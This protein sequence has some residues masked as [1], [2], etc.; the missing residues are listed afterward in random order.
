MGADDA[1][2][3]D[4]AAIEDGGTNADQAIHSNAASMER[5]SVPDHAA[6]ADSERK[7]WIG[8]QN[9]TVL[10]I[11]SLLDVDQFV[12]AA[13]HRAKPDTDI[14]LELDPTNHDGRRCNPVFAGGRCFNASTVK[15]KEHCR[16]PHFAQSIPS[17]GVM[18]YCRLVEEKA[19]P[20][21]L[22]IACYKNGRGVR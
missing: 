12:V 22:H 3:A 7:A 5:G 2:V 14:S 16:N 11:A 20:Y 8:V 1:I 6:L 9:A 18:V 21:T 4:A 19:L 10:D 15:F 13:Q 17:F